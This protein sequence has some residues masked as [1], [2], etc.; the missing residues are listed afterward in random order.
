M[1][2][3]LE[4][5]ND[6]RTHAVTRSEAGHGPFVGYPT[7]ATP[8][9]NAM[10]PD[11]ATFGFWPKS[12]D[13]FIVREVIDETKPDTLP[14]EQRLRSET[15]FYQAKGAFGGWIAA[16]RIA[17]ATTGTAMLFEDGA[18]G[19]ITL[20]RDGKVRGTLRMH[21][22]DGTAARPRKLFPDLRL[23]LFS[24]GDTLVLARWAE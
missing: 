17:D 22:S 9:W 23:G 6:A 20:T 16:R 1:Y 24:R 10:V 12:D 3:H 18:G 13:V 7:F 21:W 4:I 11:G 19:L 5:P 14:Y 2:I 15:W 8:V